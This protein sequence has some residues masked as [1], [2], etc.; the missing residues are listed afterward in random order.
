MLGEKRA[1]QLPEVPA[2]REAGGTLAGFKVSSWNGLAVP[3]KTPADVV[4]R[5]S[6][7]IQ[8]VMAL[9]DV[10]KRLLD[11]NLVAHASTPAQTADLL[12][13]D[14]RRWTEVVARAR[15]SRQ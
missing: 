11:L 15:I 6:R 14:V 5:L 12:A 10:K 8:A 7:A 3:A 4:E 9:P 2:V 1:V 13:A